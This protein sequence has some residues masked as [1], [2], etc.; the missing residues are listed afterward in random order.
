MGVSDDQRKQQVLT[1]CARVFSGPYQSTKQIYLENE[2]EFEEANVEMRIRLADALEHVDNVFEAIDEGDLDE[3][4]KRVEILEDH[5]QQTACDA[6][7]AL[8]EHERQQLEDERYLSD[9]LYSVLSFSDVPSCDEHRYACNAIDEMIEEGRRLEEDH[10][11]EAFDKHKDAMNKAR[12]MINRTPRKSRVRKR[13]IMLTGAIFG[14]ISG[15]GFVL[16]IVPP[17]ENFLPTILIDI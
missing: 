1:V 8:A 2:W 11:R 4:E 12:K 13:S 7:R 17:L 5:A 10:W 14:I 9:R 6:V 15:V 16:G 3:A